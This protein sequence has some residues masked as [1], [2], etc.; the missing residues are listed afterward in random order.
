[1]RPL[2]TGTMSVRCRYHEVIE[3]EFAQASIAGAARK[4]SAP[5]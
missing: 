2:W 4:K 1:M 3:G 5:P